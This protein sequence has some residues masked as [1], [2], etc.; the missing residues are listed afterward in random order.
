MS[1]GIC[2]YTGCQKVR[3]SIVVFKP[4]VDITSLSLYV[5]DILT[6]FAPTDEAFKMVPKHV[7]EYLGKNKT[8]LQEL[9]MYHA[10]PDMKV[11]FIGDRVTSIFLR[12]MTSSWRTANE[13]VA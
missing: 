5:L 4:R 6:V 7:L 8:A 1:N 3:G 2:Y 9:L 13:M 12:N 11:Y 10:A